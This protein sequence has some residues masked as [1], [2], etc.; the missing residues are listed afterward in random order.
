MPSH[1]YDFLVIGAGPAGSGAATA[2]ASAGRSVALIISLS[3][4]LGM[5]TLPIAVGLLAGLKPG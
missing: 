1:S 5:I 2:A 4:L 3:T